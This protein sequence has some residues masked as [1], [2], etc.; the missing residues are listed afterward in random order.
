MLRLSPPG[1]LRFAQARGL[2]VYCGEWGCYPSVPR[3]SLLNWYRDMRAVLESHDI[4]WTT[5]DYKG[6]FGIRARETEA[7]VTDLI[8]VLVGE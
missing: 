2:P 7:P 5:W 1:Y 4:A 8:E 6:G 3:E